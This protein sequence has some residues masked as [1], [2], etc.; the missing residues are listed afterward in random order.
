MKY[1]LVQSAF[2]RKCQQ[3]VLEP[4][5]QNNFLLRSLSLGKGLC[6]EI[7]DSQFMVIFYNKAMN[8][9]VGVIPNNQVR[10]S[11]EIM[12]MIKDAVS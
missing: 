4:Q 6:V 7:L 3:I 10:F 8:N 11:A 5:F 2:G 9:F 12:D 1:L